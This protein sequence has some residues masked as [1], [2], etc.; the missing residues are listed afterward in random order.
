MAA[1]QDGSRTGL[2]QDRT[3]AG[4]FKCRTGWMQDRME[5]GKA[6]SRTRCLER[7]PPGRGCCTTSSRRQVSSSSPFVEPVGPN[8]V[9]GGLHS[10]Q[11][12]A[13]DLPRVQLVR[14]QGAS[15]RAVRNSAG[16]K[17]RSNSNPPCAAAACPH[18]DL[19]SSPPS[20]MQPCSCCA[21]SRPGMRLTRHGSAPNRWVL[22]FTAA[23]SLLPACLH[24]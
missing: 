19:A 16:G 7:G 18:L 12:L 10:M 4:Q 13:S 22:L 1:G 3:N 21:C 14:T 24:S 23:V 11:C 15:S 6:G 17:N 8:Q 9:N 5:A 2:Q 20:A